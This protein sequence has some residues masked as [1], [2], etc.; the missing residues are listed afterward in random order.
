[1]SDLLSR[2]RTAA[3]YTPGSD[4]VGRMR[5]VEEQMQEQREALT[6]AVQEIERLRAE[7]QEMRETAVG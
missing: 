4:L 6:L 7:L 5:Y 3:C 2:L 1:M